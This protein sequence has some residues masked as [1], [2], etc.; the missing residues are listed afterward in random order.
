MPDFCTVHFQMTNF[1]DPQELYSYQGFGYKTLLYNLKW[2]RIIP[3]FCLSAPFFSPGRRGL[4]PSVFPQRVL[5]PFDRLHGPHL[6]LLQSLH[7][8]FKLLGPELDTVL[9]LWPR[10]CWLEWDDCVSSCAS[11]A[12]ADAPQ[13]C[14]CLHCCSG[15]VLTC[16]QL[17]L[18]TRTPRSLSARLVPS[19]KHP[20]LYWAPWLCQVLNS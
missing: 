2:L 20:S 8:F 15:V 10:K 11:N 14:I 1:L 5:Q 18:S 13:D 12:P 6:D 4:T 19:H 9:Q 3:C 16:A 17:L 7:V